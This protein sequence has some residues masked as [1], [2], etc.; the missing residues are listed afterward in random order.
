MCKSETRAEGTLAVR[1]LCGA[2]E[3]TAGSVLANTRTHPSVPYRDHTSAEPFENWGGGGSSGE[4]A[5]TV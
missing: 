3:S 5:T 2:T 4:K 1:S